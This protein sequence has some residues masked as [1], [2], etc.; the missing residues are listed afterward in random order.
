MEEA[1]SDLCSKKNRDTVN[2]FIGASADTFEGHSQAKTWKL[3]K[4]LAPKN[5]SDPPA[6]KKD[7]VGNLVTNKKDLETLYLDTYSTR[8]Q[9]N[10]ITEKTK[11]LKEIKEFLLDLQI[12]IAKS[13]VT[14]DWTIKD[15]EKVLKTLKN[16]KARDEHGHIYELFKYGGVS[17]KLSLL[18]LF[19]CIKSQQTYPT[20]LQ[21]SNI[22]SF[23]KKKGDKLDLDN[24]RGVFN[25]SKVRSILDKLIYNDIYSTIDSNMSN[26]NIG[27]RKNR[28]IRDHLFVINGI[29]NDVKNSSNSQ[30]IDI[31]IYDVAKCFDKLEYTNTAVDLFNAGIQ[32]D[33]FIVVA[34]SN[35]NCSV[36]I[37]TPWGLTPRT[38]FTNI[39][40][41]GTVLAGIKCSVSIDSI[42]KEALQNI[43]PITYKYKSCTSIPPLALIDDVIAVATCSPDSVKTCATIKAKI[44][45]KQLSL[46]DKKCFQ[47]HVGKFNSECVTSLQ[48]N[49]KS[50]L[51]TTGER[52]LGDILS[53]D[54]KRDSHINDRY[55][56]GISYVNQI[57]SILKEISFGYYYYEQALQF[58]NAKLI[59]G[60]LCSVE[61]L[62]GLTSSHIEKLERCDRYFM[63]K[64]FNAPRTTPTESFYLETGALP[65]RFII[66]ARRLLFYWSIL[67]KPESELVKQVFNTQKLKPVKND[68]CLTVVEDLQQL[69]IYNSENEI[70][71]MKKSTFKTLITNKIRELASRFLNNLKDKHIKSKKLKN[72]HAMQ[73]YL[74][75][76][77][78]TTDEKQLLFSFRTNTFQCKENYKFKYGSDLNCEICSQIDSQPHLLTCKV[79]DNLDLSGVKY[80]DIFGTVKEQIK[81][82]KILK[83]IVS[84]RNL[85]LINSS[86]TCGSQAHQLS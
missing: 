79:T 8:L 51:K 12:K 81:I 17:L 82:I 33:K 63:R 64:I 74:M 29:I 30:D 36:A 23:W 75:S 19:N 83:Q 34:N 76:S 18:K 70:A 44:E 10:I 2:K 62:Y 6:A 48:L 15:L 71:N 25:V 5:P 85:L 65:I 3:M 35:K 53:S 38:N 13:R 67:N 78:L 46:G 9:P 27:A 66:M 39:E 68:W 84:K 60:M 61:A 14:A 69:D 31:Q 22:T 57:L 28:N 50:M 11:E 32:D 72:S 40:M 37:K 80:S 24:D 41:Q 1:I 56:K 42:G 55:N 20:I 73:T 47:M 86:S 54:N 21:K 52:Y 45:A 7:A 26:S 16:N 58:R 49:G 77:E 43:H 59:N 4:K